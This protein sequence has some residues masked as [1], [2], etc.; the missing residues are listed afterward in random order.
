MKSISMKTK[1]K[2]CDG[3]GELRHIFKNV[4]IDGVRNRLCKW[5]SN[6]LVVKQGK[7]Y[8]PTRSQKPIAPRSPKRKKQETQYNKE[9]RQ[10]KEDNPHCQAAIPGVCTGLTHDV[11]HK[12]DRENDLLLYQPWWL[13]TCRM[14]HKWIHAHPKEARE[15]NL[16]I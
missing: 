8:K 10:F 13:A 16:L 1:Q 9:A 11:H 4:V 14:C 12:G 7:E 3:C 15:L 6:S 5:C 2:L